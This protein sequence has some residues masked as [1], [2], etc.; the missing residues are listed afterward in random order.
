MRFEV[1]KKTALVGPTGSGK[2]SIIKLIER[3]YDVD[4]GSISIDGHDIKD[5]NLKWWRSNVGYVG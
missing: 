1:G 5:T 3:F 4:E 2:S